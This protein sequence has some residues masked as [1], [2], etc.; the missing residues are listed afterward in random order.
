MHQGWIFSASK[1]IGFYF[2]VKTV[3]DAEQFY[4]SVRHYMDRGRSRH[5]AL[6]KVG[7]DLKT[8]KNIEPIIQLKKT[9][10]GKFAEVIITYL[11]HI[12]PPG[13][14]GQLCISTLCY[15]L[16]SKSIKMFQQY[17]LYLRRIKSHLMHRVNH[18][19]IH[20]PFQLDVPLR[21]FQNWAVLGTRRVVF[22]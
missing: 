5:A 2:A 6:R 22:S 7:K 11:L 1:V 8:Y 10:P 18:L 21:K 4:Q 13:K 15:H 17:K 3:R 9:K 20:Q 14:D 16:K 12:H 19:Q